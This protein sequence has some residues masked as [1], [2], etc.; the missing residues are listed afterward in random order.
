[1]RVSESVSESVRGQF[2]AHAEEAFNQRKI[3]RLKLMQARRVWR[4][5]NKPSPDDE[6]ITVGEA[7]MD[8]IAYQLVATGKV[9]NPEA[10]DWQS[11]DWQA[12]L[13]FIMQLLAM[14]MKMF[15]L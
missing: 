10:I 5:W 6:N 2:M 4:N 3:G 14:I 11:I 7:M 1:M 8:E 12:L 9:A 13:D 15:S